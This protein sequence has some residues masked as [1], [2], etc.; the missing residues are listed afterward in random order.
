MKA[1]AALA[2]LSL[3]VLGFSPVH[4][5]PSVSLNGSL[6]SKAALLVIDGEARTISVGQTVQGVRLLS[7]DDGS[8]QIELGGRRQVLQL[9]AAPVRLG[10]GAAGQP[11]GRKVVL[12]S[13]PGGHFT[14]VGS[15]NGHSSEFLIDT[16]ATSVSI[17]QAEAEKIG[18]RYREGT[19]IMT[20]TAN[21]AVPAHLLTLAS[22]RI[23]DVEVRNVE[24]IVLPAQMSHVLLG[25][26]FL[27]RFQMRR[28]NDTM[29]LDLRY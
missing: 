20:Q 23:G 16:G 2:A 14:T 21:G 1:S 24:A 6:G 8:V 29:T 5:E 11:A 19:R 27:T 4:A 10:N 22:V 7:V 9:G 25:N 17:S 13:G 15:I 3:L 12:A 26:S 18:L 28:E